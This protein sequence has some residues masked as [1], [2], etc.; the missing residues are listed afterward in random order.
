MS[1]LFQ[2]FSQEENLRRIQE[3]LN[4]G[5]APAAI[6]KEMSPQSR[7]EAVSWG[8]RLTGWEEYQHAFPAQVVAL[9]RAI[10]R[11]AIQEY[12]L[13]LR[14]DGRVV[15]RSAEGRPWKAP[16]PDV[17]FLLAIVGQEALVE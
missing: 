8:R 15:H 4:Q 12:R 6:I 14:E 10:S 2:R 16:H 5:A 7:D 3:R 11:R 17:S 13:M 1:E 9:A